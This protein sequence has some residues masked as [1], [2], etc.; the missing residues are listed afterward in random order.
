M[1]RQTHVWLSALKHFFESCHLNTESCI[2]CRDAHARRDTVAA[3]LLQA[4]RT[5]HRVSEARWVCSFL[6]RSA[7]HIPLI[8]RTACQLSLLTLLC[9]LLVYTGPWTHRASVPLSLPSQVTLKAIFQAE[10]LFYPD[11]YWKAA[12]ITQHTPDSG[13]RVWLFFCSLK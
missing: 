6:P 13:S 12:S 2:L 8:N 10:T 1:I 3:Q 4:I 11:P 9:F 7:S 5:E